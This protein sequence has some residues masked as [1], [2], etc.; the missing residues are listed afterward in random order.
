MDDICDGCGDHVESIMH[1][2]WLHDQAKSVWRSDPR[3][4]FLFRKQVRFVQ[5]LLEEVL[6]NGNGFRVALFVTMA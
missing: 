2:L 3:F 4:S 6:K 1:C 5:D